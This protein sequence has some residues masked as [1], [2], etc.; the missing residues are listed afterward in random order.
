MFKCF[1]VDRSFCKINIYDDKIFYVNKLL[2][3]F[4]DFVWIYNLYVFWVKILN[5]IKWCESY[6]DNEK[7]GILEFYLIKSGL[8]F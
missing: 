4:F 1:K 5:L 2:F 7:D 6:F 8:V 3:V